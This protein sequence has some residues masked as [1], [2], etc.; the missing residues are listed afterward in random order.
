MGVDV[1]KDTHTAVGVSPFGEKL[2]ELT[3]GNYE[4]DF[5]NLATKVEAVSES[6]KLTPYFGLEDCSGFGQKLAMFLADR[7]SIVHVPPIL[8][9]ERRKH[10]THPE[11]NDSLDALGVARVMI[12][13]IDTLPRYTIS[14]ETKIAKNIREISIDREYLVSERSRLKNQLH[15]ILHRIWNS[16]YQQKFKDPFSLKALRYWLRS[17]PRN[18]DPFV[19]RSMKRKIRRLIDLRE[20]INELEAELKTMIKESSQTI[21]TA[22][23]CGTVIAAE[24][25]GEV[26]DINRFQSPASLAKYAG[27]APRE[28]SSGKTKRF[29]K[30]KSGNRRLNR[31]FHRMALS[32]MSR[33]GNYKAREYFKRKVT[34]GKSK[35]QALVCLR[36]QMVNIIWMM[37]KH[38]TEYMVGGYPQEKL[39]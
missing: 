24:I 9:D 32:Q 3:V 12:Q 23:G 35:Q 13:R 7:Y 2:F 36:R 34:E 28:C 21:Q 8:V 4:K 22:S 30:T 19:V 38:K 25:I 18:S 16:E 10:E 20:E 26:G 6:V 37:M 39:P 27:C 31:A 15:F 17:A 1:H 11:K 33:S 29:R 14:K 5:R